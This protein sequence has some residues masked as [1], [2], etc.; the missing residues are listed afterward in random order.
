M[1][2]AGFPDQTQ[3]FLAD[4]STHNTK[5]WFDAHRSAYEQFYLEPARA[6]VVAAGEALR[7]VAPAINAEPKVNGSIFRI[8]RDIRFSQDKTPYKDRLDV[9]FWEGNRREAVSG[10]YLRVTPRAIGIGVG[11]HRFDGDR[12]AAFRSAVV[13]TH[14]RTRLSDASEAATRAGFPVSGKHYKRL[15]RGF[16]NAP[17][18]AHDLLRHNALWAGSDQAPPASFRTKAFVGWTVR[19]WEKLTPLHRWLVDTLQ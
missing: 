17:K 7:A 13:H 10:Y 4:L 1:A 6:F 15:P 11:T 12:L 19:R 3:E 2:F 9:W 8:N 5:E 14:T 18:D 16:E